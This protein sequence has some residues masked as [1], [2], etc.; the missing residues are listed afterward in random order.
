MSVYAMEP[1]NINSPLTETWGLA[2]FWKK[3]VMTRGPAVSRGY[4]RAA[5]GHGPL[6][7]TNQMMH[8]LEHWFGVGVRDG[9]GE[10]KFAFV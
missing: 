3:Q 6:G 8:S 10:Y 5:R 1:A 9:A 2:R 7:L 4:G